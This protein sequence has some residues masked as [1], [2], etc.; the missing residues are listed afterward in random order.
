MHIKPDI[1]WKR[2]T[3]TT[4]PG[5]RGFNCFSICGWSKYSQTKLFHWLYYFLWNRKMLSSWEGAL[6]K[7]IP[8]RHHI[9]LYCRV[10]ASSATCEELTYRY[11][12]SNSSRNDAQLY[13]PPLS[14]LTSENATQCFMT[15]TR[16]WYTLSSDPR[17]GFL[18][19]KGNGPR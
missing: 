17:S 11:C 2:S 13:T 16:N 19:P 18:K 9:R 4:Y 7:C 1:R 5:E 12:D 6:K 3:Q 15:R 8:C 10:V 14:C